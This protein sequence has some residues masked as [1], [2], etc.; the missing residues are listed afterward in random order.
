MVLPASDCDE[1]VP[2]GK[3]QAHA[4][5]V[6]SFLPFLLTFLLVSTV[7]LQKIVPILSGQT[8]PHGREK[9]SSLLGDDRTRW[10]SF[11]NIGL[12]PSRPPIKRVSALAFST[13][14]ALAAVLAELIL[15]EISNTINPA[16]RGLA[17]HVTVS[18]LLFL[19][20]IAIPFLEIHSVITA[21]GYDFTGPGQG[22]LRLAWVFQLAGFT[23]WLLGFWWGGEHLLGTQATHPSAAA[24]TTTSHPYRLTEACLER[25]G[26]IGISFMS[27]LSGFASVSSPWHNLFSRPRHVTE[28]DLARKQVGLEATT[29]ML[30][31]KRSRLQALERKMSEGPR[32]SFFHKALGSIRGNADLTE[33]K[34]LELEIAGLETMS[35]SLSASLALQQSRFRDQIRAR[36]PAGRLILVG[37]SLFSLFCLYRILSTTVTAIHRVLAR[38]P[39]ASAGGKSFTP[40]DP[41]NHTL[42]LLAKHYDPHLDQGAWARQISFF[43]SGLILAASIS[44]VMQTF[45]LLARF[46]PSLLRAVQANLA[47]VVAQVC[48][49]YVISAALMLGGMMP[50]QVVG[51]GLRGLG[52]REMSWVDAWFE[53]WFLGGVILTAGGIWLGRKFSGGGAGD[54][55]DD[56]IDDD[57]GKIL[58][59]GKRS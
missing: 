21:A 14:I 43:L 3:K 31:V 39:P 9:S 36:T 2:G 22:R 26:V 10:F 41:V 27:L 47:L 42:S 45:R 37:S 44:S 6:F 58:E 1:C 18:L 17:F 13:T 46:A 32:E 20:I 23:A 56:D 54:Y 40:S 59:E 49:T 24:T 29:E 33:R 48:A 52:G 19:L 34:T 38:P 28:A 53:R 50:G 55:Y 11:A 5:I 51:E 8:S 25:V 35:A 57:G 16:A 15:C 4:T 12:R 30:V 7:V